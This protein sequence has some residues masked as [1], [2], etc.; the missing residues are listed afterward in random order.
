[1]HLK[2]LPP[3]FKSDDNVDKLKSSQIQMQ[4][5]P[6]GIPEPFS[7]DISFDLFLRE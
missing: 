1:M 2:L 5:K 4:N 7:I 6:F 3:L